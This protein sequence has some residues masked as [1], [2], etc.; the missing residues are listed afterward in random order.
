MELQALHNLDL[1]FQGAF[2]SLCLC[3]GLY[4]V[5]KDNLQN[6]KSV[7]SILKVSN[8][9]GY[10]LKSVLE[11]FNLF[12]KSETSTASD[13]ENSLNGVKGMLGILPMAIV[14]TFIVGVMGYGVANKWIDSENI[15]HLGLKPL[16]GDKELLK[17][18]S[19]LNVLKVNKSRYIYKDAQRL[20]C[21][22]KV[23]RLG[24]KDNIMSK[25]KKGDRIELYYHA[26]HKIIED[27]TFTQYIQKNQIISEYSRVFALGFI[28]VL[29]CSII[30]FLIMIL[31]VAFGDLERYEK[32]EAKV[33]MEEE[34]KL[35][36]IPNGVFLIFNVLSVFAIFFFS[37]IN[38]DVIKVCNFKESLVLLILV[39]PCLTSLLNVSK[40]FRKLKFSFFVYSIVYV[41]SLGGYLYSCS[42]W[43]NSEK[44]VAL[45][46]YGV[47]LSKEL[48]ENNR[49]LKIEEELIKKYPKHSLKHSN[50]PVPD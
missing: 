4:I 40:Q 10:L 8:G 3:F 50:D 7:N 26:K 2:L 23:F 22:E 32:S 29:V 17:M 30:N 37:S 31:R 42:V 33:V 24:E 5:F 48:I 9:I 27:K 11:T 13:N 35:I 16:W 14:L 6:Y 28:F 47:Y 49:L 12:G 44:Q 15:N 38:L 39:F 18:D 19:T 41:I 36:S 21:Y 20:L 25:A 45:K 46:T 43:L 34:D 1:F